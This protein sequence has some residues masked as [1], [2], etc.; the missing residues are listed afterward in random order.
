MTTNIDKKFMVSMRPQIE[1]ELVA[2]GKR[3]GVKFGIGHGSYGGD[4]GHFK[5]TIAPL[6]VDGEAV[7]PR[8]KAFTDYFIGPKEGHWDQEAT[9][10]EASDIFR[11]F[12][13]AGST[14]KIT[15]YN[16]KAPKYPIT[17]KA[18]HTGK[19]FK[20]PVRSVALAL[21]YAP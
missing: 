11:N 13:V 4:S 10:L 9:M 20:F 19:R 6:D 1:D 8:A 7:D 12:M 18:L 5:L 3:L 17:A 15:G 21:G 16:H 2:M 14:Y